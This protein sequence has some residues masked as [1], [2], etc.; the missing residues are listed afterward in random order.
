MALALMKLTFRS[1]AER[2]LTLTISGHIRASQ[3][4]LVAAPGAVIVVV[5]QRYDGN[6]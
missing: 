4:D 5:L 2:L 3:R 6:A 1:A